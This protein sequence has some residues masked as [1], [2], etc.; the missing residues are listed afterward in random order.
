M[1]EIHIDN[2][3]A[4]NLL[5][6]IVFIDNV[7]RG[8]KGY[9]CMG[10]KREM[11]A[12]KPKVER[13]R[14]YFRHDVKA[15][16]D[17]KKC[18]FSDETYRHKLA[19][20]I[21]QINKKVKVPAIYKFPPKGNEGL[22]NLISNSKF[23]EAYSVGI[24]RYF[25][26][27]DNGEISFGKNDESKNKYL[28]I[29]PD[30]TFFDK[31]H[32]PILLIELVATHKVTDDKKIRIKRLG[33]DTIQI[34][35][36]K[37]SPEAIS[38]TFQHTNNTKWIYNHEQEITEYIPIPLSN[39]EGIQPVDEVQR[40]L[41]EESFKCR[42]AQIG[43]LLQTIKRC[44]G[45]ELY[46]N[47]EREIRS[48]FSRVEKNTR[49]I[50]EQWKRICEDRRTEINSKYSDRIAEITS[51]RRRVEQE[52]ISFQKNYRN[53]EGRY[54][55]KKRELKTEEQTLLESEEE[56]RRIINDKELEIR[57]INDELDDLETKGRNFDQIRDELIRRFDSD[58]ELAIREIDNEQAELES[59]ANNFEQSKEK[60][61]KGFEIDKR[62]SNE[63]FEIAGTGKSGEISRIDETIR[64]SPEKFRLEEAEIE[65]RLEEDR[66]R[67]RYEF[68][69]RNKRIIREIEEGKV[70]N[71]GRIIIK[72]EVFNKS[73]ALLGNISTIYLHRERIRQALESIRSS[74]YKNWSK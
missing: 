66:R 48:E 74:A 11:Q 34:I 6:E 45:S 38:K 39:S 19:K 49:G 30:V 59:E 41:F 53:L 10:C 32:K 58:K 36:P 29:K 7:E 9:F 28:L 71:Y 12:V 47:I 23:I 21:L 62:E 16:K 3:Y 20:E 63:I 25:F 35:I 13:I 26:E 33:I 68:D 73:M 50:K 67:S 1:E 4:Y 57:G 61:T 31:D 40:N 56:S 37:D 70:G 54:I 5:D 27:D 64:D 43:N 44:L 51:K 60:L 69:E 42:A 52:E 17:G 18:T 65:G 2:I 46:I 8:R 24:E 14:S 15:M 22:P 55:A 72:V